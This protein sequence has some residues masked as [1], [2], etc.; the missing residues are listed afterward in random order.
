MNK[1]R[2]EML[3]QLGQIKGDHLYRETFEG[4]DGV[5]V[6]FYKFGRDR[7]VGPFSCSDYRTIKEEEYDKVINLI[8][9]GTEEEIRAGNEELVELIQSGGRPG[10]PY[11]VLD[12]EGYVLIE[13]VFNEP[14]ADVEVK[15]WESLSDNDLERW[16]DI[17]ED[18]KQE[19]DHR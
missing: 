18:L 10:M 17:L 9:H 13:N 1:S 11:I 15:G 5:S 12:G 2:N 7:L 14:E 8:N 4:G 6:N 19:E 16:Y 3:N